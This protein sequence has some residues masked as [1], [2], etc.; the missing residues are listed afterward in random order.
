MHTITPAAITRRLPKG[1]RIAL[2]APGVVVPPGV[3]LPGGIVVG[4]GTG[5]PTGW[6][7]GDPWP[8]GLL[9]PPALPPGVDVGGAAPPA[10][11]AVWAPGPVS[12]VS[13]SPPK[14]TEYSITSS[15]GD[16]TI[17]ASK[18]TFAQ[19]WP[20]TEGNLVE[21]NVAQDVSATFVYRTAPACS[22]SRAFIAFDLSAL[23]TSLTV[24]NAYIYLTAYV[25]HIG[26]LSIQEGTQ[27]DTL[28]LGDF[29]AFGGAWNKV[30][31]FNAGRNLFI[32][33]QGG[34]DYIQ[35]KLGSTAK[36]CIRENSHDYGGSP[37]GLGETTSA[38]LY[39]SEAASE[40][41]RPTLDLLFG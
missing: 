2:I 37:P 10:Y 12:G 29:D 34:I 32:L 27:G 33:P 15:A 5:F 18:A 19:V 14:L 16:G 17:Y 39:F 7:P 26:S 24:T 22:I 40:G 8:S 35:S 21:D 30:R 28:S 20:A 9:P 13:P 11:T 41:N 3:D 4:P 36:F 38:G 23:S 31:T 1:L 6:V 25:N